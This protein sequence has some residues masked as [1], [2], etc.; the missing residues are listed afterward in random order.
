MLDRIRGF[1]E[2]H[3]APASP[4]VS[5]PTISR[6]AGDPAHG[7]HLATAALLLEVSRADFHVHDKELTAIADILQRQFDFTDEETR[8]LLDLARAESDELLSLH[9][10]VRLINEHFDARARA[11]IMEDLWL[12]AYAKGELDKH[13]EYTVRKIAD[14]LYVPHSVYIRTKLKVEEQ[15]RGDA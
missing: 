11:R 8:E 10:F 14:L 4:D 13:Q 3:I 7:L 6:T 1:F 9:P 15:Q 5:P 2:R 12:V